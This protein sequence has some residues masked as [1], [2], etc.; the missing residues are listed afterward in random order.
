MVPA[1]LVLLFVIVPIAELAVLI[2]VGRSIGVLPT[3]LMLILFSV[4]GAVIAKREGMAVWKRFKD[5]L[6]RGATPSAEIADGFLVLLG[7]ALL[8]TP[9]FLTD[10]LG[11]VLVFP[12]S[13]AAVKRGLRRGTGWLL[14]QRFPYLAP[15]AAAFSG[16]AHRKGKVPVEG[17]VIDPTVPVDEGDSR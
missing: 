11:L 15:L 3:I 13:R 12:V 10:F 4:A 14:F 16:G 5:S 8:L 17:Q 1:L 2:Q 6:S 7:G 9:G